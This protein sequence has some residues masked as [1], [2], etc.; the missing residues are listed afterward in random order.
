MLFLQPSAQDG[1]SKLNMFHRTC[2]EYQ[3][4]NLPFR[5]LGEQ[6]VLFVLV[7][8]R[9]WA[10]FGPSRPSRYHVGRHRVCRLERATAHPICGP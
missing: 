7:G 8:N 2:G 9:K 10:T 1:R 3:R 4:E 6:S 5:S